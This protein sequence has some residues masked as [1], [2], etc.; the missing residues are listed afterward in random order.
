MR[1]CRA[2]CQVKVIKFAD[3]GLEAKTFISAWHG[4]KIV[5]RIEK[6]KMQQNV[7]DL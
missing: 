6:A 4:R 5:Q 7:D 3:E 2:E 1:N